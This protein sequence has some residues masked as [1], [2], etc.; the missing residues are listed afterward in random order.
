MKV[1]NDLYEILEDELKKIAK[2][3]DISPQEL[4]NAYK[5][6]D[7]MK[8]IETIKAMKQAGGE[9]E[10]S[11]RGGTG[12]SYNRNS[13][14]GNMSNRGS[15][16]ENMS[17][18]GSYGPVWNQDMMMPYSMN[19]SNRGSYEGQ[20]NR[21]SYEGEMSNR[22][23][24][25]SYNSYG[26]YDGRAGR[27]A[28]NDGRYSEDGSYDYS[29]RRGRDARGR[30]TSRDSSYDGY[31]RHSEKERMIDKLETMADITTD[32]KTK[33]AIEQCIDKLER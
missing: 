22:G 10:Y 23:S 11:Q 1:M 2:K 15:Y 31:S 32:Q 14:D 28:D 3:A 12:Y 6:V 16:D 7:I 4:E 30:Y 29:E 25:N 24:Y 19:M 33:R 21:G 5:A 8:D 20:S 27:D 18:R 26:S 9:S 13:F 17:N